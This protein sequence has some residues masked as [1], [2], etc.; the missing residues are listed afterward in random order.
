MKRFTISFAAALLVTALCGVALASGGEGGHE[1]PWGNY[2]FRLVN[3]ALFIGIIWWAAGKKIAAL[4][5]GRQQQIKK[6]LDDLEVRQA[7]AEKKLRDVEKS[8][9]NL[10]QEKKALLEEA[11]KQGEALKAAIIEKAGKDAE[12]MKAQAKMGAENEAKAAVEA[13]RAQMADLIVE[14]ATRIVQEK[15]TDQD[16]EKLVDEYLTKVVLN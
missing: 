10:D 1:I 7:E 2:A 4:F 15:L 6:D 12:L 5:T 3:F 13:L 9:A 11:R 16:H 14:A 8:I